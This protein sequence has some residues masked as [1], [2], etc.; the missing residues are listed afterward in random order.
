MARVSKAG[1]PVRNVIVTTVAVVLLA[2]G[3]GGRTGDEDATREPAG[4]GGKEATNP[5]LAC[6]QEAG[7]EA[8]AATSPSGSEPAATPSG[9]TVRGGGPVARSAPGALPNASPAQAPAARPQPGE[10]RDGGQAGA[11]APGGTPVVPPPAAP[12]VPAEASPVVMGSVGTYSG[13]AASTLRP[14]LEG[15]QLWVK[16][17]NGRGGL[18]RHPV[19]L[20]VF[21]DGGD[22]ARHRAQVQEA[23]EKRNVLGFLANA[24]AL[25]GHGSQQYIATKGVPVVGTEGAAD[26]PYENPMYF[27]QHPSGRSLYL[28]FLL[29]LAEQLK[30]TGKSKVATLMCAE[31][32]A[33]GDT[34]SVFAERAESVGLELVYRARPSIAQPDFT[35][36]CLAARNAGAETLYMEM[37]SNSVPRIAAACARQGFRPQFA[38]SHAIALDRFKA[39]PNL[40]GLLSSTAYFPWFQSG[41]PATDEFQAAFEAFGGGL[42]LGAGTGEG[43]VAGKL[44]ERAGSQLPEPPTRDA[45]LRGLWSVRNDDLGGLTYPLTF[46][47]GQPA[48]RKSC[49]FDIA[50]RQKTWVSAD[51]FALRCGE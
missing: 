20:I 50:V 15:A 43:W 8:T 10:S 28:T 5:A 41:T 13:P 16:Y 6:V 30:P 12:A 31:A 25:T 42:I 36:E 32:Q 18:N 44:L 22:P 49:W 3:C 11:S 27:V 24:E 37:D 4:N 51:G 47:Q 23:I 26:Y 48:A 7:P 17:I 46:V 21:D 29:A 35:A 1:K 2:A 14:I 39:D 33:C 45:L 9:P 19:K 34:D 38:T 40:E